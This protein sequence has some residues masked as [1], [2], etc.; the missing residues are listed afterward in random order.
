MKNLHWCITLIH[1]LYFEIHKYK[2]YN[3]V[4]RNRIS[5]AM[6]EAVRWHQKNYNYVLVFKNRGLLYKERW[7]LW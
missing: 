2:R 4:F 3:F 7:L 6:P 1:L 5:I